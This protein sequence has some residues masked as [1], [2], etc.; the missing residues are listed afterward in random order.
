[1]G[2]EVW[3]V[4]GAT[5]VV[6]TVFFYKAAVKWK[7]TRNEVSFM[8]MSYFMCTSLIWQST[9]DIGKSYI[10]GTS[11]GWL[12]FVFLAAETCKLKASTRPHPPLTR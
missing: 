1:M 9:L 10:R 4:L 3:L 2:F 8:D 7:G 11:L 6:Y 5:L 12:F